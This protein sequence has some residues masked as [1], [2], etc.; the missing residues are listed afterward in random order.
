[1]SIHSVDAIER[2]VHKTNRWLAE[3]VEELKWDDDSRGARRLL[4][5]V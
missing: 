2:S 1:M 5:G 4:R 3:L